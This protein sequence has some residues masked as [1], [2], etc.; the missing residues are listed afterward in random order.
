MK[1]YKIH[2][3]C[4][5]FVL[6]LNKIDQ[7]FRKFNIKTILNRSRIRK[8]KGIHP[9]TLLAYIMALPFV[10]SNFFQGIV[11]KSDLPFAKDAAYELLKSE[12]HNWR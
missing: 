10:G 3:T 2:L 1:N 12:K 8:E 11:Q 7:F 5:D 9:S 4:Q 6:Y